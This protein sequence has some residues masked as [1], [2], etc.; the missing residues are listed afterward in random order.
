MEVSKL[1]IATQRQYMKLASFNTPTAHSLVKETLRL[2][3]G[4]PLP[5]VCLPDSCRGERSLQ[6]EA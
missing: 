5:P 1:A 3:L 4:C 6:P 2:H